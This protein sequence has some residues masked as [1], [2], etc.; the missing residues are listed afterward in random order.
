MR[1]IKNNMPTHQ[2][3]C[4]HCASILEYTK[5]DIEYDYDEVFDNVYTYTKIRCPCCQETVILTIDGKPFDYT[6]R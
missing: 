3:T 6:R 4:P 5:V 1:V 2:I